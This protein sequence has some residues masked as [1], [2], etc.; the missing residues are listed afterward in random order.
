MSEPSTP[1]RVN[2]RELRESLRDKFAEAISQ[3]KPRLAKRLLESFFLWDGFGGSDLI[4]RLR[5]RT[6]TDGEGLRYAPPSVPSDRR[7]G[8]DWWVWRNQQELDIYRQ[9]SRLRHS[10]NSYAQG[11]LKNLT[12]NVIGKGF[13]Y[14]AKVVGPDGKPIPEGDLGEGQKAECAAVQRR[15]ERFLRLNNWNG[16]V[17]PTSNDAI[18]ATWERQL[19]RLQKIDGDC[20][21]RFHKLDNGDVL[22]RIVDA[23]Q[24]RE[25]GGRLPQEGWTYGIQHQMEPYEDVMRPLKY[26]VFWADMSGKGGVDGGKDMGAWEEVDAAD[27]L[28][29][30][31]ADTPA[32]VKRGLGLFL[33]DLGK[34]L[35]RAARLQRNLSV[36]ASVRAGVA[37]TEQ[38]A[39]ATQA[40]LTSFAA[41]LGR[42]HTDGQGH[43]RY[44][45]KIE[46]G[47]VRRVPEGWSLGDTPADNTPSYLEGVQ[48]DLQQAGSGVCAP[49]YWFGSTGDVNYNNAESAAAPAVRDGQT[50]QE[51]WKAAF[52]RCVWKAVLWAAECGLVNKGLED[53]ICIQVEAPAVL[54]RNELEKAQEDQILIQSGIK[55]RQTAAAER[56]LDWKQVQ[57]NNQE[58]QEQMGDLGQSLPMPGE[59][60]TD[61]PSLPRPKD[62]DTGVR[63]SRPSLMQLS[64]PGAS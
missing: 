5:P 58:Y 54:H 13:S 63:E 19:F 33:F 16:I 64:G 8:A 31:G 42:S 41:A 62:G 14:C 40:Q 39:Q 53:R 49:A 12:N 46:P 37:W 25:G 30:K 2:E 27:I 59:G 7:H 61:D 24:V 11:L 51:Y 28:H 26:L 34:A 10:Q 52:A 21:P 56:G 9:E 22:I 43:T 18:A 35:D 38:W 32:N 48:G 17:D 60:K 47:T 3:G 44:T 29:I 6:N 20:F 50:E 55:D 45:E 23:A 57:A 36:G 4:D 1:R 15:I